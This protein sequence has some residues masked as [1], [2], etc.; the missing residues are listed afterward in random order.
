MAR[1]TLA[2]PV[3]QVLRVGSAV[4]KAFC[5]IQHD[6]LSASNGKVLLQATLADVEP[7]AATFW[8]GAVTF[9]PLS[10]WRKDDPLTAL[11]DGAGPFHL[12]AMAP[13]GRAQL[14]YA[15]D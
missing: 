9:G 3:G 10:M 14:S 12:W 15:H 13:E 8:M 11:F 2:L 7:S 5:R 4:A 6:G 1:N